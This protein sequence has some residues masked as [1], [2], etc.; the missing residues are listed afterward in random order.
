MIDERCQKSML[1]VHKAT[2]QSQREQQAATPFGIRKSIMEIRE[3]NVNTFS[4]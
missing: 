1:E 2:P 3:I 4:G